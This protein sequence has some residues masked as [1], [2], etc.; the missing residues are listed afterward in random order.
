MIRFLLTLLVLM[1]GLAA[2]GEPARACAFGARA[3]IGAVEMTRG[4]ARVVA[5]AATGGQARPASAS[6]SLVLAMPLPAGFALPA[7]TVLPGIDRARE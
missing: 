3:E 1:S 4:S 2:Q 5:H 7:F 6:P